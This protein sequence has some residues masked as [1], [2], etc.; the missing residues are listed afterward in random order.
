MVDHP[1]VLLEF[2][3]GMPP[4]IDAGQDATSLRTSY[5]AFAHQDC[6][7][8]RIPDIK[9]QPHPQHIHPTNQHDQ[10]QHSMAGVCFKHRTAIDADLF[11]TA[12]PVIGHALTLV[13]LT[14]C[15]R[16]RVER[17]HNLLA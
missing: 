8:R 2:K 13:I 7:P 15:D 11:P 1:G 3:R 12:A 5:N 17:L 4:H 6:S 10:T 14:A 9:R 16:H